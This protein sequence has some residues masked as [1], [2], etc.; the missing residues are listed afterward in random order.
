M[1]EGASGLLSRPARGTSTLAIPGRI[2]MDERG[3]IDRPFLM[4][5]IVVTIA[6]AALC[7]AIYPH[8]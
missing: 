4:F 3:P 6:L 7:V 2:N 1:D 8:P 5:V